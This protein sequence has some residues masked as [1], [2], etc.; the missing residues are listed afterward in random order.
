MKLSNV[1]TGRDAGK[2]FRL[3][4]HFENHI[5]KSWPTVCDGD[6]HIRE[7]PNARIYNIIYY[8]QEDPVLSECS[9]TTRKEQHFFEIN[10]GEFSY[11]RKCHDGMCR[12]L[13][14]SS[15]SS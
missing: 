9:A 12:V 14:I 11:I 13:S 4:T 1:K 5:A 2:L 10:A 3:I 15:Y 6:L 7:S 8:D